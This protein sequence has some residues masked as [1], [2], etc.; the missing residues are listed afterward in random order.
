LIYRDYASVLKDITEPSAAINPEHIGYI[1]ELRDGAS[2]SGVLLK[3]D[4]AQVVLGQANGQ[5]LAIAKEKVAGMK[6][7][8]VS[9]MPEGLLKAL[10][11]QQQKDLMTFL[12]TPPK[13]KE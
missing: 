12:L 7:S 5:S 3:N 8:A 4:R 11:A 2:E 6:A 9:I 1:V 10:D 13:K